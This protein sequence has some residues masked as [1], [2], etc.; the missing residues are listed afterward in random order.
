MRRSCV[1]CARSLRADFK[2]VKDAMVALKFSAAESEQ[3]FGLVS[4]VLA[5]GNIEFR[6]QVGFSLACFRLAC[7]HPSGSR[8]FCCHLRCFSLPIAHFFIARAQGDKK[9]DIPDKGWADVAA[10]LL[11]VATADLERA[12]LIKEL[13]Y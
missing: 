9:C 4:A 10:G 2:A 12:I 7:G 1:G 5:L 8:L 6:S 13:R 11:Q 3:V